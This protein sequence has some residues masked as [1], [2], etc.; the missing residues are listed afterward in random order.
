MCDDNADYFLQIFIQEILNVALVFTGNSLF[1]T[2]FHA[3]HKSN[4]Q[5]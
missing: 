1:Y 5:F 3:A 4:Y 2:Y